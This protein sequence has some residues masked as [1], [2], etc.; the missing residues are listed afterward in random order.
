MFLNPQKTTVLTA[1]LSVVFLL[2]SM[3]YL[4]LL[5]IWTSAT[6]TTE[7]K[8]Y[9]RAYHQIADEEYVKR[10]FPAAIP[11]DAKDIAFCYTPQ[12]LQGGE[13]FQLSYCTTESIL[14]E[15]TERL[16]D[17]A[18][19]IGSNDEWLRMHNQIPADPDPVR[20]QLKY[21]L[22]MNGSSNHGEE[23]YVLIDRSICRIEFCYSHW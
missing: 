12:I 2:L 20:Y 23:C 18:E 1:I 10:V 21:E 9:E 14:G 17:T 11:Q 4:F 3:L 22:Y 13:V 19:W 16:E 6:V 7:T 5:S 8:Y 15:W